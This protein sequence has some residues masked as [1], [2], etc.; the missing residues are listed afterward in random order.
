MN[1]FDACDAVVDENYIQKFYDVIDDDFDDDLPE[2]I[3]FYINPFPL[4]YILEIDV[5][6][7]EI[8]MKKKFIPFNIISPTSLQIRHTFLQPVIYNLYRLLMSH[9]KTFKTIF[10]EFYSYMYQPILNSVTVS[11]DMNQEY[12]SEIELS[13]LD[14]YEIDTTNFIYF[15]NIC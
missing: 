2:L 3:D 5:L 14:E 11:L 1:F 7:N 9:P 4:G 15:K 13:L 10:S 8:K 12:I 6:K